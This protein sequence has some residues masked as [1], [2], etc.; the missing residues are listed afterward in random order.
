M[1]HRGRHLT[2]GSENP[3]FEHWLCQVQVEI[4]GL[5]TVIS[6]HLGAL[7][8]HFLTPWSS[9]H[10]F[11]HTLG[12]S[13]FIFSHL[14]ALYIHFLTPWGSLHLFFTPWSSLQSFYYTLGLS[15]FIL[16]HLGALYSHF[17]T[18]WGSLQS[19]SH[20]THLQNKYPAIGSRLGDASVTITAPL[21]CSPRR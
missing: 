11:S 4:L 8:I 21:K 14:G 16:T 6:L 2:S 1:W 7:Y 19:F 15:T 5:F 9:L 20:T 17:L 10:S 18:P 3:G 13:T 12:L